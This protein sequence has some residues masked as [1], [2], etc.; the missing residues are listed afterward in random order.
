MGTWRCRRRRTYTLLTCDNPSDLL[1]P[2]LTSC[3]T[4][5]TCLPHLLLHLPH[6]PHLL[7][8]LPHLRG[9]QESQRQCDALLQG[10]SYMVPQRLLSLFTWAQVGTHAPLPLATTP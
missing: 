5:L 9:A 7:P 3:L 6:L 8:H 1:R 2:P 10:L 4:C